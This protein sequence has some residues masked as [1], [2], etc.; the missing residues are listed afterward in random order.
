MVTWAKNRY[1]HAYEQTAEVAP[2]A[3]SMPITIDNTKPK[4]CM[5]TYSSVEL[6]LNY[7]E[8]YTNFILRQKNQAFSKQKYCLTFNYILKK[9]ILIYMLRQKKKHL[10]EKHAK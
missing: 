1:D 3:K 5:A 2:L 9:I 4:V 10:L 6:K 7:P 8:L